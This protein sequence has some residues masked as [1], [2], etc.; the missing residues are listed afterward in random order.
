M[1]YLVVSVFIFI[2][3]SVSLLLFITMWWARSWPMVRTRSSSTSFH[4]VTVNKRKLW[5]L[6]VRYSYVYEDKESSSSNLFLF[7]GRPF[8][9]QGDARKFE[10]PQYARV[11]PIKPKFSYLRQ[12][13]RTFWTFLG[14]SLAGYFL[15]SIMWVLI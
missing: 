12:D 7:G 10:I 6:S 14:A 5:I 15:S 2:V 8:L 3:S 1:I 9:S 11:C 4:E 13:D